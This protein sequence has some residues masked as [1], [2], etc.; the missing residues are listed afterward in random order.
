MSNL[1]VVEGKEYTIATDV[2]KHFGYTKDYILLLI[3]EG[4]IEGQKV[5]H[6]WY[7]HLP[8]AEVFFSEA[9]VKREVRRKRISL[10]RKAE[11][12]E[13]TGIRVQGSPR[14]ALLETLVIVVIGLTIGATG[15][16]GSAS[17]SATLMGEGGAVANLARSLYN[18]ISPKDTTVAVNTVHVLPPVETAVSA[19]IATTTYTSLVVAPD[20]LFTAMTVES[21]E[22]SFSDEVSVSVDPENGKTG[23]ITP[24]F[25]NHEGEAYRFLMVP[26]TTN[27]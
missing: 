11:L 19:R 13:H 9:A 23:I 2:G 17:Q 16:L 1:L 3:K 12:R 6:K 18:F 22:D 14:A 26:V 4:K 5:G 25:K 27:P 15:Y 10:E 24:I 8:S 20:E 21:I 7:A